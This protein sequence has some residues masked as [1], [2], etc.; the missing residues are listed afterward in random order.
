MT[1]WAHRIPPLNS[2]EDVESLYNRIL[3]IQE[4]RLLAH[5]RM[6]WGNG[7]L[8][9][10]GSR[11]RYWE[12]VVKLTPSEYRIESAAYHP[13]G[14]L[15][16]SITWKKRRDGLQTITIAGAVHKYGVYTFL[17]HTLPPCLPLE[18]MYGRPCIHKGDDR[19]FFLERKTMTDVG[20]GPPLTFL[21]DP[22]NW[23]VKFHSGRHEKSVP[24]NRDKV[25]QTEKMPYV[26]AA[27]KFNMW[28]YAMVP[29]LVSGKDYIH[30][31]D[32]AKLKGWVKQ[33][34]PFNST[35]LHITYWYTHTSVYTPTDREV[36]VGIRDIISDPDDQRR[37]FLANLFILT[38][39]DNNYGGSYS[40]QSINRF[41]NKICAFY[42]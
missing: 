9:P 19:W 25:S 39:A 24:T 32:L 10:I 28:M 29:L 40:K 22:A 1:Y 16:T 33:N 11:N 21:F 27:R 17:K 42:K 23:T 5:N 30:G 26:N 12:R 8:R 20:V 36:I 4:N 3:P 7:D 41:T 6:T 13:R 14:E 15:D 37:L 38:Q 2:F 18:R 31:E 35:S 34:N